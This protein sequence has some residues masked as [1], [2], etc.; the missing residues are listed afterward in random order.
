MTHEIKQ[1]VTNSIFL[2]SIIKDEY[3]HCYFFL[4]VQNNN[5][6]GNNFV[7]YTTPEAAWFYQLFGFLRCIHVNRNIN[8][9]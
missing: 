9:L 4:S 8:S 3:M 2:K 6:A 5:L 7:N 1:I